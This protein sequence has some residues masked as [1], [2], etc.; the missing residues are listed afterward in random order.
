MFHSTFTTL[1]DDG[2]RATYQ[3]LANTVTSGE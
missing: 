2:A 1:F 3:R